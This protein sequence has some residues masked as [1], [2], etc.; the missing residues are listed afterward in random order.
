MDPSG[1]LFVVI[2]ILAV[3]VLAAAMFYGSR[4]A[5]RCPRDPAIR[6]AAEKATR[7]LYHPHDRGAGRP[8]A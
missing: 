2:D 1:W 7:R 8:R 3:A 6:R 4:L 5:S